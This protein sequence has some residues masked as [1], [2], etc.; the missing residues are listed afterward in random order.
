MLITCK[1]ALHFDQE[2]IQVELQRLI[3]LGVLRFIHRTSSVSSKE[4]ESDDR[5][6]VRD[7]VIRCYSAPLF[8]G[9]FEF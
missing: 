8:M 7:F 9:W 2:A 4:G 5:D 3:S 6:F 1:T